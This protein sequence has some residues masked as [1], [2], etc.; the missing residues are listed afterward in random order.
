MCELVYCA[1]AEI[2]A[3]VKQPYGPGVTFV[4][5]VAERAIAPAGIDI[6]ETCREF[7]PVLP[8]P[9]ANRRQAVE[10]QDVPD[11]G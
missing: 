9:D 3:I 6:V 7:G 5:N 10:T 11:R 8:H 1:L 4:G 2:P